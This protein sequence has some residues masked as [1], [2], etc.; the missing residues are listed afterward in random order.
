MIIVVYIDLFKS[1]LR[2]IQLCSSPDFGM[3]AAA[4][5][6]GQ[7]DIPVPGFTW[8]QQLRRFSLSIVFGSFE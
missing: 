2:I 5:E 7:V 8:I 4:I 6:C 3:K 1:S